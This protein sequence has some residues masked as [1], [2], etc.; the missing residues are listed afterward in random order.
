M[1]KLVFVT[2]IVLLAYFG[3]Y[4]QISTKEEPVSFSRTNVPALRTNEKTQIVLPSLDM[5]KIQQ[6][7]KEDEANGMP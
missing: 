4:G 6:E 7:D 2:I 3:V 1:K 5:E